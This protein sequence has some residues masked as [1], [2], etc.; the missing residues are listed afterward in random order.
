MRKWWPLAAVCAGAFMLLV[1]VTIVN[2][3]LPDMAREL[4]TTF[5]DLQWVID[6]YALVLGALV[7]TVGS[8]ADRVG[9][10]R[11]YLLGLVVFAASSLTCGLARNVGVLI[12]ARGVQGLGAA[13]MF[14]TTIALISSS[15]SGRDRGVAFG[16]W[17]AVNGAA[18]AAGPIIGGLLTAH[19]GWR[20]IFLVNLPVSVV[21]VALTLLVVQESRDPRSH[22]VDLPGMASFTVAATALTYALIR[23]SWASGETIALLAVAAGALVVFILV[24]R[25]R[26]HPM[27][28][29]SLLRNHSFTALLIAGALLSAAAWAPMTY[30]SLW[31]QSVLGLSPIQAGLVVLP[32]SVA[33]FATSAAIGRVLYRASPHLLIGTGLLVIAAG[34]FAQAVIGT[35]SGWIV[36]VPGLVLVGT[37]A[38]LAMAPLSATAMAAVPGSRA[39][40][41]G[42]AISSFRQ[43]GY[44]FGI[45]VLGD[46]FRGGV[47]HS[48]SPDLASALSG[49]HAGAVVAHSPGL[50]PLVHQAFANGLDLTFLVAGGIGV[51]AGVLVFALVRPRPAEAMTPHGQESV[52]A[53]AAAGPRRP[54]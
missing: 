24:E 49:G 38:G 54:R 22:G 35:E 27:L 21:A 46:V 42:G 23:G 3:A 5:S 4:H 19:F 8:I 52:T 29:L 9:R 32:C 34:A 16:A 39:G 53:V 33:A 25:G 30:L 43:L 1:D 7:L 28:D 15:Y 37:G 50:A 17:G 41:A 20:W 31:L 18:A 51:V 10:R 26:Q 14:A 47:Q 45:A 12:A 2:V 44:A 48:V 36:V 13:A 6:L 40:M 11:V